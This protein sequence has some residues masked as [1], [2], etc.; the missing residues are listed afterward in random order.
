[1]QIHQDIREAD[2]V[3][4]TDIPI[5]G[6]MVVPLSDL[7][8]FLISSLDDDAFEETDIELARI[9]AAN[10]EA[11]LKHITKEQQLRKRETELEQQDTG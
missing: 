4:N 3:Y 8:V 10:T 11:A 7:G 6:E 5:R 2:E 1:M 9:L